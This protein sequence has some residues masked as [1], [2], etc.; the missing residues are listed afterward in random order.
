MAPKKKNRGNKLARMTEEE[1]LRYLQHKAAM[2]EE[3]QRRKQELVATFLKTK[4]I[5]EEAFAR[6]NSAKINQQWRHI[7]RQI[8]CKELKEDMET[9]KQRFEISLECKNKVIENLLNDFQDAE[10]QYSLQYQ[11]QMEIILKL[12]DLHRSRLSD[13][14]SWYTNQV[15]EIVHTDLT[16]RTKLKQEFQTQ[17]GKLQTMYDDS[18]QKSDTRTLDLKT[19]FRSNKNELQTK[20][21]YTMVKMEEKYTDEIRKTKT[22]LNEILQSHS[23][24]TDTKKAHYNILANKDDADTAK[25]VINFEQISTLTDTIKDSISKHKTLLETNENHAKHLKSKKQSIRKQHRKLREQNEQILARDTEKLKMLTEI[26]NR[27]I[28]VR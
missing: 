22:Q 13:L 15:K 4:M 23:D 11:T 5:H 24:S 7:L 28:K 18:R 27:C 19:K 17:M 25:I 26:S 6:L 2:E 20:L 21:L 9:M 16:Q 3:A 10:F 1:K 8:K 14:K 12:L